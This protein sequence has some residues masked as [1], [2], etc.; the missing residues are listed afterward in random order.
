MSHDIA[1]GETSNK[2]LPVVVCR[3]CCVS[4]AI[5][6]GFTGLLGSSGYCEVAIHENEYDTTYTMKW[7]HNFSKR[8]YLGLEQSIWVWRLFSFY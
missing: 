3:E 6:G 7:H 2:Y 5:M 1:K 8:V 4:C